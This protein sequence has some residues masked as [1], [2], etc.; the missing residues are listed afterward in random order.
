MIAPARSKGSV[1]T[2]HVPIRF[3]RR[4][5]R[6]TVVTSRP[7]VASGVPRR[8]APSPDPLLAAV[9]RA[10]YW[11]KLIDAGAWASIA[12]IAAAERVSASYVSRLMRL[13]LL[14]PGAVL[15]L[16]D[17]RKPAAAPTLSLDDLA[18]S[19]SVVWEQA[20]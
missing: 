5:G 10:F 11:R 17:G 13:T 9:A 19:L 7:E 15:A 2:V 3:S 16:C 12:E 1:V 18:R 6:K 20:P 4:T 8:A 14:R